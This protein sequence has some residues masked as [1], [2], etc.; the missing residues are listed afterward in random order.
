MTRDDIKNEIINL[1]FN[2]STVKAAQVE[3]WI[4]Q[5]EIWV[6]NQANW[7]FKRAPAT[8]VTVTNGVATAPSDMDA[9]LELYAPTGNG[10]Y[11]LIYL[12]PD[13]FEKNFLAP[14]PVPAGTADFYT[15]R[16][17]ANGVK[18]I[19]AGPSQSGSFQIAY[20][21]KYCHLADGAT[22]T[23]GVMNSANDTPI[24]DSEHHYVLVPTAMLLG[25]K[26]EN[27]P[28][29]EELRPQRDE[30]ILSMREDLLQFNRG[31]VRIWGG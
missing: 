15:V 22:L 25:M 13:D 31:E 27:D 9:A 8:A 12:P 10:G 24:W 11:Q 20:K 1:R 5:A 29:A 14:S 4:S 7:P 19:L 23:A 2:S 18:Q 21:R 26:L 3:K 28:T 30:M 6:W 16:T 17:S